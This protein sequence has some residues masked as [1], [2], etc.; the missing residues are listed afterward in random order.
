MRDN[1]QSVEL[2]HRRAHRAMAE[3]GAF[4]AGSEQL[5]ASQS[6]VSDHITAL[7][8]LVGQRLIERSRGRRTVQLTEAGRVLLGHAD[9]IESRLHAAEADFRAYAAGRSGSLRVGIYQSVASKVL[10][11]VM[12]GLRQGWRDVEVDVTEASGDDDL[13][14]MVERGEVDLSF[15]IQPIRDGPFEI[16]ELM[17]DPYVVM[18]AAGSPLGRRPRAADLAD[19]AMVGFQHG[20]HEDLAEDF[21][22][23]RGVKPRLVFG[24]ADLLKAEPA[25]DRERW[26]VGRRDGGEDGLLAL[27][28]GPP[29]EP[30]GRLPGESLAAIRGEDG[31]ADLG[32]ADDLGR[33]VEAAVPDHTFGLGDH[34]ARHPGATFRGLLHAVEL[35]RQEALDLVAVRELVG[36]EANQRALRR[37]A[38][39]L[40]HPPDLD[41]VEWNEVEALGADRANR[42][43]R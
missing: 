9:A 6:T 23:A 39:A 43:W 20:K 5:N 15:A 13:V 22:L 2:K 26:C 40:E 31:V 37:P 12:R 3:A 25:H 10:P 33:S 4:W 24:G 42:H 8:A 18:S 7:E 29:D 38:I 41:R 27:L 36:E 1:G 16:R 34:E 32:P 17:R 30:G 35:D 19:R 14:D 28:E 21:L 11:E